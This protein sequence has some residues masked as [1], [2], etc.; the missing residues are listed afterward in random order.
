MSFGVHVDKGDGQLV[1]LVTD[2]TIKKATSLARAAK[3]DAPDLAV[4]VTFEDKG[5]YRRFVE[6]AP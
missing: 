3:N 6:V 5:T 1:E 4:F 2:L